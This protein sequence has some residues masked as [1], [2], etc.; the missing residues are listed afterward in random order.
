[1]QFPADLLDSRARFDNYNR[2]SFSEISNKRWSTRNS[3]KDWSIVLYNTLRLDPIS[4]VVV[5]LRR[6]IF[7]RNN[8]AHNSHCSHRTR[9]ALDTQSVTGISPGGLTGPDDLDDLSS[10]QPQVSG[11]WV[12]HLDA[13]QLGILQ[14]VSLQ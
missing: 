3:Y 9:P 2:E 4:A 7:Y 6:C 1:M 8:A 13:R 14:A 11:D 12:S 10:P 5:R